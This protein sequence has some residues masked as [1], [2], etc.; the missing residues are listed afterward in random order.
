MVS[1]NKKHLIQSYSQFQSYIEVF[2][3]TN[4]GLVKLRFY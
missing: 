4:N 2:I 3:Q 1:S